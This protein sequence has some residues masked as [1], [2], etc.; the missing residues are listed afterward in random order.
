MKPYETDLTFHNQAILMVFHVCF[1]IIVTT[2]GLNIVFGVILD[3]FSELRSMKVCTSYT[4]WAYYWYLSGIAPTRL[5]PPYGNSWIRLCSFLPPSPISFWCISV[6]HYQSFSS[7]A[8]QGMM[9]NCLIVSCR[10][11]QKKIW[12]ANVI[13]VTVEATNLKVMQR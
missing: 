1:W 4:L 5:A 2:I 7:I 8:I 10:T 11:W 9:G 13:S 12:R 6:L 3:T